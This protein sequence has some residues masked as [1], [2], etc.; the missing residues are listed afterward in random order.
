[1]KPVE[2]GIRW[3]ELFGEHK[4]KMSDALRRSRW[5]EWKSL[6]VANG[7]PERADYWGEESM[8]DDCFACEYKD[9]DWCK[10]QSL[11]CTVNPITTFS[12]GHIGMACMGVGFRPK[13]TTI[14]FDS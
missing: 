3:A 2:I 14:D 12:L 7:H 9:G 13:Q 8:A 4:N 11:P 10:R 6:N 5:E 1:M